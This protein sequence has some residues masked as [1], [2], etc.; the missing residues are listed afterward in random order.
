MGSNGM[1]QV[2]MTFVQASHI[3]SHEFELGN[4]F[5]GV[6]LGRSLMLAMADVISSACGWSRWSGDSG[7]IVCR[8]VG[9]VGRCVG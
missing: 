3:H 5:M 8:R 6:W 1:S 7:V 4:L 9:T 2:Q